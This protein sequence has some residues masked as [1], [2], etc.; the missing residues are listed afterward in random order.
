MPS[1]LPGSPGL[2]G[3]TGSRC[4]GLLLAAESQAGLAKGAQWGS[5]SGMEYKQFTVGLHQEEEPVR[6]E[7][8]MME[9][10]I[11]GARLS[12]SPAS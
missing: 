11:Q 12:L 6:A 7:G 1:P 10:Q 4:S 5:P 2:L 8:T 3:G 9:E